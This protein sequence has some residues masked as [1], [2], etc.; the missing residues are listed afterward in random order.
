M[1]NPTVYKTANLS[2]CAPRE[3][4]EKDESAISLD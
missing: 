4:F 3:H 2:L 1:F